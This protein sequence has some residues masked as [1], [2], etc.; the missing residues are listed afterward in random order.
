M[1][2]AHNH[3]YKLRHWLIYVI[4]LYG[5]FATYLIEEHMY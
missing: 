3:K 4:I 2:Q 1:A 5:V